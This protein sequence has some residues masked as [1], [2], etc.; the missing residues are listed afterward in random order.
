MSNHKDET[1]QG[2]GV[3][4]THQVRC[5]WWVASSSDE[6]Q[7]TEEKRPP[8]LSWMCLDLCLSTINKPDHKTGEMKDR[9]KR[10]HASKAFTVSPLHTATSCTRVWRNSRACSASESRS[11]SVACAH[12]CSYVCLR[13][14][15]TVGWEGIKV[16]SFFVVVFGCG[17]CAT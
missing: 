8:C 2:W 13:I 15:L 4:K 16:A 3:R 12:L 5:T 1:G 17:T 9:T 6:M 14:A 7:N 11:R 10:T